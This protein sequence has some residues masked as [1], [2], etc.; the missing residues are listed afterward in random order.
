M[1]LQGWNYA[2][3]LALLWIFGSFMASVFSFV[4]E[5]ELKVDNGE[6]AQ[7]FS[8]LLISTIWI[9]TGSLTVL[10]WFLIGSNT[11]MFGTL[12][13]RESGGVW[14]NLEYQTLFFGIVPL[15]TILQVIQTNTHPTHSQLPV[16]FSIVVSG[17]VILNNEPR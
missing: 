13:K 15:I 17:L 4:N 3:A 2:R 8:A 9:V 10:G 7:S 14:S 1:I 16:W 12:N 6:N 5:I 11:Q